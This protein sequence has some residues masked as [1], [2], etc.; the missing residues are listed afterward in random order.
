[1]YVLHTPPQ[2]FAARPEKGSPLCGIAGFTHRN[3]CPDPER[4][5]KAAATLRHR[6]P[7]QMG[8][9]RSSSVS[10][11]AARL[12]IIDLDAGD[13]PLTTA[14]G[15]ATIV[16]N[17]EIY[18]HKQL[19]AELEQ[20]GY[21]FRTNCDTEIALYSFVEWNTDCFSRLRG[22]FALAVW[23]ESSRTLVL[24]R[25]RMGIKPL[26]VARCN[27]DLFFGSELKAI[28]FHPQIER[29][30]SLAGLDCYLSLNYVPSPLTLVEGIEKLAPG[31]WLKWRDGKVSSGAY[32]K[33][34]AVD[35]C[36][37]T[38]DEA[39]QELDLLLKQS[40]R[41]HLVSDVPVGLWLS[42]GI[43]SSTVL[44]YAAAQSSAPIKT[45]SI[46]FAGRGCDESR[47]IR[48]VAGRYGTE[49]SE[50]DLNP[51]SNL[52]DTI[53]EFAYYSDDPSA[54]AGALP[55]WYLSKLSRTKT[56]VALSGEGADELFGGYLTYRAD[57]IA[58]HLRKFPQKAL[59]FALRLAH[60]YPV[61]DENIG[62]DYKAKRLLEGCLFPAER[63][64]AFWNG[65]FTESQKDAMLK[66][67]LPG[68]FDQHLAQMDEASSANKLERYLRFDQR[69]YLPDDILVKTDRMSM[70]HALEVRPPFLDHRIVQFAATL[71][72]NL[73]VRGARQKVL[74]KELMRGKL[75]LPVLRRK[76][77]GFDIPAHEWMR[78]PLRAMLTEIVS[79]GASD[80]AD[81][82]RQNVLQEYVNL[83]LARRANLGYHLWG[84]M[85]LF[86][87]MKK[88]GIQSTT[89][90]RIDRAFP[91]PTATLS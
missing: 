74:L 91:Q 56:T 69:Y 57:Q 64:H 42:G 37:W 67:Y 46:S 88:W 72:A 18:N 40:V 17:G 32:W 28:L 55:I 14:D 70:A 84:L 8:V 29:R 19:R 35:S 31:S 85:I 2:A 10:M 81:L 22:M 12:K 16:F 43:D 54:D 86:L 66:V 39:K 90:P 33:T 49:H 87:W 7:D 27:G 23:T 75:P 13:Q 50:F 53:E 36:Q 11:G 83:H 48:Q 1:M 25:D 76:K 51:D 61:S 79:D 65:T 21:Q 45:F 6:G 73:K 44:H 4:I 63:A 5:R 47:Y 58:A 77:M 62:F 9:F 78:G 89:E 68:A 15:D 59:R 26:Y 80:H 20:R 30:L 34:P 38:L 60:G 3:G 71:P 24:A 41:E 82:F 52:R